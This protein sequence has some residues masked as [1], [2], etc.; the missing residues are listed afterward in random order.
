MAM[1]SLNTGPAA[2]IIIPTIAVPAEPR[3]GPLPNKQSP[4]KRD[5]SKGLLLGNLRIHV[6]KD[7]FSTKL[8]LDE[9][10]LTHVLSCKIE[11]HP[12]RGCVIHL[13]VDAG[14]RHVIRREVVSQ[15]GIIDLFVQENSFGA[16]GSVAHDAYS[17]SQGSY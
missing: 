17:V 7:G 12:S 8:S 16:P 6:A 3:P 5:A 13:M 4:K 9:Y 2:R 15:A 14:D 1:R 11:L 10:E